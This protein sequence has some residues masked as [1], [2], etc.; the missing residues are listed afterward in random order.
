MAKILSTA[1]ALQEGVYQFRGCGLHT[2]TSYTI[3]LLAAVSFFKFLRP[4]FSM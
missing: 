1:E 4:A 2:L 3:S